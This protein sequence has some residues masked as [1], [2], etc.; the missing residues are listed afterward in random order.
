MIFLIITWIKELLFRLADWVATT[1]EHPADIYNNC[2]TSLMSIA[3]YEYEVNNIA[4]TINFDPLNVGLV[5]KGKSSPCVMPIF[6]LSSSYFFLLSL[7]L[8]PTYKYNFVHMSYC[9]EIG[10]HLNLHLKAVKLGYTSHYK[11]FFLFRNSSIKWAQGIHLNN[12]CFC[13]ATC[14]CTCVNVHTYIFRNDSLY[15]L[16]SLFIS[17]SF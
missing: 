17:K 10:S 11:H 2:S 7:S 5:S 15:K 1:S 12:N 13:A 9:N 4:R 6:A 8:K 14:T 16:S 3:S